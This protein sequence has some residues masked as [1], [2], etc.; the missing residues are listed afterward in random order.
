MPADPDRSSCR[1]VRR[2]IV[3]AEGENA[4][5]LHS[6]G[7]FSLLSLSTF[8]RSS[9]QAGYEAGPTASTIRVRPSTSSTN[10]RPRITGPTRLSFSHIRLECDHL[11][12]LVFYLLIY[13]SLSP[14]PRVL[15]TR[16]LTRPPAPDTRYF[17][18]ARG[19]ASIL[20]ISGRDGESSQK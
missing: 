20:G 6:G 5:L 15:T 18:N 19:L 1:G 4:S 7:P 9:S 13:S 8:S 3:F 17:A 12:P 16:V 14:C 2:S 11:A 10:V